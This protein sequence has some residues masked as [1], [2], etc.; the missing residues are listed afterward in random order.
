MRSGWIRPRSP[1]QHAR[2]ERPGA[3]AQH[4]HP[5]ADE[6]P[7]RERRVPR[8][9]RARGPRD[10]RAHGEQQ[11]GERDPAARRGHER[12]PHGGGGRPLAVVGVCRHPR[13]WERPS[14]AFRETAIVGRRERGLDGPAYPRR[15]ADPVGTR[16]RPRR[17]AV[18]RR[19]R[20]DVARAPVVRAHDDAL[21]RADGH[22]LC[23]R[24]RSDGDPRHPG[25]LDRRPLR[26]TPDDACLRSGSGAAVGVVPDAA[27][28]RSPVVPGVAR[29]RRGVSGSSRR[30]ISR[31]SG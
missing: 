24:G 9:Q 22:R 18:L 30:R 14:V 19:H 23:G 15:V 31:A 7:A 6:G 21:A 12:R 27:R 29:P 17:G 16:D 20:D 5:D 25:G 10:R 8:V 4:L 26:R 11:T 13:S 3:A 1:A 2:D 28:R